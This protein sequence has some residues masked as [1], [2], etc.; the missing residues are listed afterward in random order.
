MLTRF[1][2]LAAAALALLA[3]G[4]PANSGPVDWP[5]VAKIRA[6]GLQRSRVMDLEGYMADVLGARLTLSK[7]MQR[8]QLWVRGEMERIGLV[9][10]CLLYTSPSPRD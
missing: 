8:A 9:N 2:P 4:V 5:M 6:E 10:V 1:R 3:A 7:D